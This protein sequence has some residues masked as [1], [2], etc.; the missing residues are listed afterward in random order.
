MSILTPGWCVAILVVILAVIGIEDGLDR[1]GSGRQ[2]RQILGQ[3]ER[4]IRKVAFTPDETEVAALEVNG[5][6]TFW[7]AEGGGSWTSIGDDGLHIWS[8]AFDPE[9]DT[10]ALGALDGSIRFKDLRTGQDCGRITLDREIVQVLAFSPDGRHIASGHEN[11]RLTVWEVGT[12]VLLLDLDAHRSSVTA[13]AFSPNRRWL[14]SAGADGR[15]NL[16][17]AETG[18]LVASTSC[19]PGRLTP[20]V[21][22]ADSMSLSWASLYGRAVQRWDLG[23]G[24]GVRTARCPVEEMVPTANGRSL[25]VRVDQERV[26]QLDAETLRIERRHR[27]PGRILSAMAVSNDGTHLALGGLRTVEMHHLESL[28]GRATTE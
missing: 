25:L 21:F 4:P 17:D 22:S 1:P 28:S 5:R 6:L 3:S 26:W 10:V 9:G 2:D 7:E 24:G 13:L 23:P 11:G 15:V 20:L 14:A 19:K 18:V 8:F 27:F 12:G 16:W